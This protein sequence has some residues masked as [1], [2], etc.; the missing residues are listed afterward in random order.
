MDNNEIERMDDDDD[1]QIS[2]QENGGIP[3]DEISVEATDDTLDIS[4]L[5][6]PI[7]QEDVQRRTFSH[8]PHRSPEFINQMIEAGFYGCNADDRVICFEC[9]LGVQC[10]RPHID[11]PCDVHRRH[12]PNC[13]YVRSKLLGLI[14]GP[15]SSPPPPPPPPPMFVI[16][17]SSTVNPVIKLKNASHNMYLRQLEGMVPKQGQRPDYAEISK[18]MESFA[19][20]SYQ[21][22]PSADDFARAGFF[23]TGVKD[24]VTCFYCN[25]TLQNWGASDNPM[26]EH[27]RWFPDC[28]YAQQLCGNDRHRAIQEAQRRQSTFLKLL[29]LLMYNLF[30]FIY[31]GETA[32]NMY[33]RGNLAS[34]SD[35]SNLTINRLL[36]ISDE[37]TL[38]RLVAARLGLS[39]SCRLIDEG[40]KLSIVR[41]CWE[42]Q[43]KIK[44][45]D[46][47]SVADIRIA[48]SIVVK[49]TERIAGNKKNIL[50][51]HDSM[52]QVQQNTARFDQVLQ[53]QSTQRNR[54]GSSNHL[55]ETTVPSTTPSMT[56][57]TVNN[58]AVDA[59]R[60]TDESLNLCVICLSEEKRL[61]CIPCG[62][63]VACVPCGYSLKTCPMCRANIDAFVRIYL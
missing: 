22:S 46:F 58:E 4:I 27:A 51:L 37:S 1:V 60:N 8:W 9:D 54:T 39:I 14:T 17:F 11:D 13:K 2:V 15:S 31:L 61:A 50:I 5:S 36:T 59:P 35:A 19:S 25:G 56:E 32:T 45:Q 26:I 44:E 42:D 49:Q 20:R 18:R 47:V 3:Y 29:R 53:R 6:E 33:Q 28:G 30:V 43:L 12:S 40:F 23:Y 62:H 63:L 16:V 57:T 34:R 21:T 55:S 38:S 48:C 41:Q 10:W 52:G 7:N 24:I